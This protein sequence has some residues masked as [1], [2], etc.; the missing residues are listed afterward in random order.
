MVSR[1]QYVCEENVLV[2]FDVFGQPELALA[3][4]MRTVSRLVKENIPF[5]MDRSLKWVENGIR[6][7]IR[8][9]EKI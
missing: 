7:E 8:F 5:R 9:E 6:Y 1:V 4:A 2:S 3:Y